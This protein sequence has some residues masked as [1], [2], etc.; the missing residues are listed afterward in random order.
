MGTEA[1]LCMR[2][3]FLRHIHSPRSQVGGGSQPMAR[4]IVQGGPSL[5]LIWN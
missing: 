5:L 3:R 2:A 1:V 4:E